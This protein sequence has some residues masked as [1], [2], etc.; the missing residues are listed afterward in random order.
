MIFCSSCPSHCQWLLQGWRWV[1]KEAV[2]PSSLTV[3]RHG[4]CPLWLAAWDTILG[5][6]WCGTPHESSF[7]WSLQLLAGGLLEQVTLRDNPSPA[8]L[9]GVYHSLTNLG[10]VGHPAQPPLS[11]VLTEGTPVSLLSRQIFPGP[12]SLWAP[13][14][15][16]TTGQHLQLFS[17]WALFRTLYCGKAE[18]FLDWQWSCLSENI[19]AS[20]D[21]HSQLYAW[22]SW[23]FL[24]FDLG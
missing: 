2:V 17:L 4:Q 16:G 15:C 23:K 11:I 5:P 20:P 13:Q 12:T 14:T 1:R 10:S 21:K 9:R 7:T 8:P 19:N 6:C 3:L 22:C 24:S 18:D